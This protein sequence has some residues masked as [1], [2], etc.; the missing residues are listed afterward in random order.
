MSIELFLFPLLFSGYNRS[1]DPRVVDI[2]FGDSDLSSSALFY[3]VFE[4]L[5]R[6]VNAIFNAGKSSS[7]LSS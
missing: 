6:C 2:V 4:L 3:V 5:Y 7:S 1:A